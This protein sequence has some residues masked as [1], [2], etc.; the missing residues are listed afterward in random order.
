VN[1]G[2]ITTEL[3]G[4]FLTCAVNPAALEE[5]A[6]F[7]GRGVQTTRATGRSER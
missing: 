1:A 3:K 6:A 2:L 7:F 5:L 4:K